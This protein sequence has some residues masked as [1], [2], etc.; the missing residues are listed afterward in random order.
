M[1]A[2]EKYLLDKGYEVFQRVYHRNRNEHENIFSGKVVTVSSLANLDNFYYLPSEITKE[3][4]D[5]ISEWKN[6]VIDIGLHEVGKPVTLIYP[7]PKIEVKKN[8]DGK[9]RFY[10]ESYD[11]SVNIVLQKEPFGD[12]LNSLTD[13][14]IVFKYDL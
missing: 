10:D 8:E 4:L 5:D 14:S 6:M 9:E 12:I 3:E 2:F 13:K 7:R 11:D 1:I